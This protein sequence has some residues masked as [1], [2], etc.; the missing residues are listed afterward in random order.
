MFSRDDAQME[1]KW[2][3]IVAEKRSAGLMCSFEECTKEIEPER[4]RWSKE[5]KIAY[6]KYCWMHSR[7]VQVE[8]ARSHL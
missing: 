4:I 6:P 7:Q 3:Q 5:R 8:Y 1:A 2:K